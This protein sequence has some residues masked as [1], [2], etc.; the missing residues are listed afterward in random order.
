MQTAEKDTKTMCRCNTIVTLSLKTILFLMK[1]YSCRQGLKSWKNK[2]C[3]DLDIETLHISSTYREQNLVR[4]RYYKVLLS[5]LLIKY[6][7]GHCPGNQGKVRERR[8]KKRGKSGESQGI[9]ACCLNV[10]GLLFFSFNLIISVLPKCHIKKS[11]KF[12]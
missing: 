7:G 1:T 3:L 9:Q 4:T 8:E 12:L 11:G 10:R 6:Q 5:A 2:T